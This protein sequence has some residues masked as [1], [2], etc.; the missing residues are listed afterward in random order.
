MTEKKKGNQSVR[1]TLLFL[2]L[3][4]TIVQFCYQESSNNYASVHFKHRNSQSG[5][6]KSGDGPSY[7]N[8]PLNFLTTGQWKDAGNDRSSYYLRAPGYGLFLAPHIAIGVNERNVFGVLI[9]FSQLFLNAIV[10]VLVFLIFF[11]LSNSYRSALLVGVMALAPVFTAYSNYLLSEAVTPVLLLSILYLMIQRPK[12]SLLLGTLIGYLVLVRPAF[13]LVLLVIMVVHWLYHRDW[14]YLITISVLATL[15]WGIWEWRSQVHEK[16]F[17][18]IEQVFHPIYD[19]SNSDYW[20]LPHQSL[21]SLVKLSNPEPIHFHQWHKTQWKSVRNG[22]K[23]DTLKVMKQL[24]GPAIS[25]F[26]GNDKLVGIG[27]AYFQT[28]TEIPIWSSKQQHSPKEIKLAA[29]L[30]QVKINYVKQNVWDTQVL[31]PMK[32]LSGLLFH[33]YVNHSTYWETDYSGGQRLIS[34]I[35]SSFF[36]SCFVL[37]VLGPFIVRTQYLKL[38]GH[39]LFFIDLVAAFLAGYLFYLSWIQRGVEKRYLYPALLLAVLAASVIVLQVLR[40]SA[41]PDASSNSRA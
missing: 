5:L 20:R 15:P 31:V 29:M 38:S 10:P 35:L 13:L 30:R 24:F 23:V 22:E 21:Y 11:K 4:S 19:A 1:F 2:F 14:R 12:W 3:F 36:F 25:L 6:V 28:W 34:I 39:A 33:S 41:K 16:P 9:R 26:L 27:S 8:P 37:A 7:L 32:V 17:D 18:S 40:R